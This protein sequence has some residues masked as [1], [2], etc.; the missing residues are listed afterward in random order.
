MAPEVALGSVAQ[1]SP[2]S[3]VLDPMCGSGTGLRAA[4]EGGL[5]AIGADI[6]PLAIIMARVWTTRLD[7][8]QLMNDAHLL[9]MQANQLTHL[10]LSDLPWMDLETQRFIEFWFAEPQLGELLRLS[11]ALHESRFSKSG[12][13]LRL[14]LS[15][16]IIA[17]DRGASL[18]RDVSHS[19]PHKVTDKVT[20]DVFT[21]FLR[22]VREI[23]ARLHPELIRGSS[24]V[25]RGDSRSL[26]IATES[27]DAVMT[28]PPY[29][30]AIDYLRGHRMALVWLGWT[31]GSLRQLRAESIG[32]ERAGI[33]L[34]EEVRPYIH[35]AGEIPRK[36]IGWAARY[37][38][39]S[40]AV[41]AEMFRVLRPEGSV[42]LVVGNSV[43]KGWT[44]D[45]RQMYVDALRLAGFSVTAIAE[46]HLPAQ[47]R[48]LPTGAGS[49]LA[50]RMRSEFVIE[51]KR[52]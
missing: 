39:D 17:K 48:Y 46:R 10:Y 5:D 14:A 12:D 18:A 21:E 41:T 51:G 40:R 38:G 30:N 44:I 16:L 37:L 42:M 45:N 6:D 32:A 24:V 7:R 50:R 2:R 33:P 49:A 35:G 9:L 19:R 3:T 27:I 20:F 47:N 36:Y 28:S 26:D 34:E 52:S 8:S 15:R 23:S 43:L 29:L 31:I 11:Y 25:T 22:S 1:L 13:A 4:V